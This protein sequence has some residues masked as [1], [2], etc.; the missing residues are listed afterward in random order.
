MNNITHTIVIDPGHGGADVGAVNPNLMVF[1][2]DINL[3]VGLAMRD[4]MPDQFDFGITRG[5][6]EYPSLKGRCEL[7]NN[8]GAAL[9]ISIHAN[10]FY[11]PGVRGL[12]AYYCN[13]SVNGEKA[14]I[15]VMSKLIPVVDVLNGPIDVIDRDEKPGAYY[16]LKHTK[17]P[18]IL[19][20]L[21]FVSN[22]W[23]AKFMKVKFNQVAMA[24]AIW[25]GV[26]AYFEA[27][28]G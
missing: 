14:A 3:A 15:A 27:I 5:S 22:D 23:Q 6:D 18:A 24:S 20:E 2:K 28:D 10:W 7:A 13:G 26:E 21:G 11:D 16:V 25:S 4:T 1:E 8:W 19:V 9:F 12:E 17:A